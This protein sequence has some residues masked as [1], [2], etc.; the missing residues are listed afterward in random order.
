MMN[1]GPGLSTTDIRGKPVRSAGVKFEGSPRVVFWGGFFEPFLAKAARESLGWT[2]A[3]CR[4]RS[5]PP[6]DYLR[7]TRDLLALL[8]E[9]LYEHMARTDQL[10]R[11]E[12]FPNRIT[13]RNVSPKVEAMKRTLDDLVVAL[14]HQ[15]TPDATVLASVRLEQP[16]VTLLLDL[17]EASRR[18][19]QREFVGVTAMQMYPKFSIQ[20]PGLQSGYRAQLADLQELESQE[21]IR[22]R[23]NATRDVLHF[24]V[25]PKGTTFYSEVRRQNG[26][27]VENMEAG[28]R[29]F[30]DQQP[31]QDTFPGAYQKWAQAER[32]L[33]GADSQ[34]QLTAIGH[35]CREAMQEFATAL[36]TLREVRGANRN[37]ANTIARLQAAIRAGVGGETLPPFLEALV[38]YWGTVS[39]L[40]QRQEHGAQREGRAL[41]WEDARRVVFQTMCVMY[42]IDRALNGA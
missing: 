17:F 11:G 16:Q 4:E 38:A 2:L 20:H 32:L 30:L 40:A 33:W 13:P 12:G 10:L 9:R 27:P 36:V 1:S 26:M 19:P 7:E 14:T 23:V 24:S 5:L 31:F 28:M 25:R 41:T 37:P 6:D 35:H 15:G 8:S 18:Q 21:L 34:D 39:D 22:L 3:L 29:R 42:E